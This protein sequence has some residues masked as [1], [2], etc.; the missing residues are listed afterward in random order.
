MSKGLITSIL[1]QKGGVGKTTTT[2]NL[3]A[4]LAE[5]DYSVLI[6]DLDPQAHVGIHLGHSLHEGL[7]ITDVF[8]ENSSIKDVIL[9]SRKCLNFIPSAE[10]LA[11]VQSLIGSSSNRNHRIKE[12][13]QDIRSEYDFIFLDCPP[14]LG[15]LTV[16]ALVAS[17]EVLVPMQ[18]HF[19]ALHGVSALF[20]TVQGVAEEVNKELSVTGLILSMFEGQTMLA[21]EVVE[22]I[23]LYL[24]SGRN[25]EVPWKKCQLF[26]PPIRRNIK[27]AEAPSFG[28]TIFEYDKNCAGAKDYL[29]L[30]KN[31]IKAKEF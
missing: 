28:K 24:D 9:K 22:E 8:L 30:A 5:K 17:Q 20:K 2:V 21:R 4:A 13:L 31:Y 12:A 23:K 19:L 7:T 1:N 29:E 25:T 6:V 14:S 15:L 18:A 10:S 3:A 27:L 16:N 11:G 26:D